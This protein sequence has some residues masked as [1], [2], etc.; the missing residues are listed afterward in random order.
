MLNDDNPDKTVLSVS[1]VQTMV[2]QPRLS[3]EPVPLETT[4]EAVEV[5][6]LTNILPE[7]IEERVLARPYDLGKQLKVTVEKRLEQR[8]SEETSFKE[9]NLE[10][11]SFYYS[12]LENN[13]NLLQDIFSPL[14][15]KAEKA[16]ILKLPKMRIDILNEVIS[17]LEFLGEYQKIVL[18]FSV[19]DPSEIA[20]HCLKFI[21]LVHKSSLQEI[22]LEPPAKHKEDHKVLTSEIKKLFGDATTPV[23]KYD[24]KKIF[25]KSKRKQR[26]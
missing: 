25:P 11:P 12:K 17:K 13:A 5:L 3:E 21:K 20:E 16:T 19:S 2:E 23:I 8:S 10:L 4:S 26:E 7:K 9:L 6:E 15:K 24:S 22:L 18:P 14:F 1:S